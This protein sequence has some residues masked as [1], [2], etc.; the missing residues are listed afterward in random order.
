MS[1]QKNDLPKTK[2]FDTLRKKLTSATKNDLI[3]AIYH[4]ETENAANRKTIETLRNDLVAYQEKIDVTETKIQ[5]ANEKRASGRNRLFEENKMLLV[6]TISVF[7]DFLDRPYRSNDY[8][9]FQRHVL[10]RF[11]VPEYIPTPRLTKAEKRKSK[12]EQEE[13]LGLKKRLGWSPSQL[14][15][16]FEKHTGVKPSTK[17]IS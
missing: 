1:I 15:N 14:R 12:E 17:K 10:S 6:M 11:P 13:I 7:D 2:S 16:F 3:V 5:S 4:L 8:I 9:K